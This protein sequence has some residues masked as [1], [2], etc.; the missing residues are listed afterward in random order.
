MAVSC[1]LLR[2]KSHLQNVF[3]LY[4]TTLGSMAALRLN[5]HT[6]ELTGFPA[7]ASCNGGLDALAMLWCDSSQLNLKSRSPLHYG[8]WGAPPPC[9]GGSGAFPF[10]TVIRAVSVEALLPYLAGSS[11]PRPSSPR[12]NARTNDVGHQVGAY[13]I[14]IDCI[15]A[16]CAEESY[17]AEI[18]DDAQQQFSRAAPQCKLIAEVLRKSRK[19]SQLHIKSF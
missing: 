2:L 17:A 7:A 6:V 13:R 10:H 12:K 5:Q 19:S 14:R 4:L 11:D 18:L 1:D 16:R 3:R 8:A 9:G 15:G